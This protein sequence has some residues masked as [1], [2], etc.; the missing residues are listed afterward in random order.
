MPSRMTDDDVGAVVLSM[1]T[2]FPSAVSD[3]TSMSSLSVPPSEAMTALILQGPRMQR[4]RAHQARQ[5]RDLARLRHQSARMVERW[6]QTTVLGSGDCW[7]EWDGRVT[8]LAQL[9]QRVE[10][11]RAR[12]D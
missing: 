11:Q 3:L 4:L 7:A 1:A 2:L 9:V 5:A 12:E 6:Y 10:R 8:E